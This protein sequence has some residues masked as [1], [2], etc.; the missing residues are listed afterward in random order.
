MD[1]LHTV[2]AIGGFLLLIAA[3][4]DYSGR[5]GRRIEAVAEAAREAAAECG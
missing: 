2:L 4:L 1:T 5:Q 3:V